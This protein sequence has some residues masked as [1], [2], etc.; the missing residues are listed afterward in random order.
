MK[1]GGVNFFASNKEI[2]KIYTKKMLGQTE[3]PKKRFFT[4]D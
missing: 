2:E 4:E 1:I 3:G